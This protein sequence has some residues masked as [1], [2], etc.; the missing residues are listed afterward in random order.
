LRRHAVWLAKTAKTDAR[1][2][3]AAE[4]LE[5]LAWVH[6]EWPVHDIVGALGN[7]ACDERAFPE[8]SAAVKTGISRAQ[9]EECRQIEDELGE[10]PE[11]RSEARAL[12]NA[13]YAELRSTLERQRREA[14]PE[15]WAV[16]DRWREHVNSTMARLGADLAVALLDALRAKSCATTSR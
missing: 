13:R 2:A 7:A 10:P 9:M 12:W 14:Q 4:K 5:A 8:F 3:C 15:L 11:G 1:S 16:Y 6:T